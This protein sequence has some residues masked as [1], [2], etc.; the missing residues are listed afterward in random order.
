MNYN[1]LIFTL[2]FSITYLNAMQ[3]VE[4][5][6]LTFP[7]IKQEKLPV[8]PTPKTLKTKIIRVNVVPVKDGVMYSAM[9]MDGG[10]IFVSKS[11]QKY[12]GSFEAYNA[13]EPLSAK[14]AEE[15]FNILESEYK[16]K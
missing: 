9:L 15:D 12:S 10:N 8:K 2:L 7:E 4:K 3:E 13:T 14:E 6:S 11:G 5:Q 16:K 1:L